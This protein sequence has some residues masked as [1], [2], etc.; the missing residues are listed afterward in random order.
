[1][2]NENQFDLWCSFIKENLDLEPV[3]DMDVDLASSAAIKTDSRS[4]MSIEVDNIM[5]SLE[6]LASKLTE[7]LDM[8]EIDENV[9]AEAGDFLA[10]WITSMRAVSAQKKVNKIKLNVIDLEFA[11]A[12]AKGDQKEALKDKKDAVKNQAN[13]LQKMIDDRFKGKGTIVDRKLAATKIEGQLEIIKRTSGMEDNPAVK[14]DLK[15]RM[16]KLSLRYKEEQEAINTLETDNKDAIEAAKEKLR[17]EKEAE[18]AEPETN[19]NPEITE[20]PVVKEIKDAIK[21]YQDAIDEIELKDKKSKKD[22]DNIDVLKNA[23]VSQQKRLEKIEGPKESLYLAALEHNL[24]ELATEIWSKHDWQFENNTALFQ[25]YDHI[26]KT[27]QNN[28]KIK[29]TLPVLESMSVAE[30]FKKLI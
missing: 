5:S 26:I 10:A 14:A 20:D 9:A 18:K 19:E 27:A 22:Q 17:Q 13:E 28:H 6:L 15:T 23:I 21:K 16:Q 4:N 24:I 29:N 25:K 1:M 8:V 11:A 7:E 2:S 3:V 12:N 30:R